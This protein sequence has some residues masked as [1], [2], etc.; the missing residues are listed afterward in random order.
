VA[1]GDEEGVLSEMLRAGMAMGYTLGGNTS[2]CQ[3]DKRYYYVE[4]EHEGRVVDAKW[5]L[6]D[7]SV[8]RLVGEVWG[9]AVQRAVAEA[10]QREMVAMALAGS[11]LGGGLF[12]GSSSE[13]VLSVT[14]PGAEAVL[15]W[16]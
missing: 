3:Y 15:W 16:R 14:A 8:Q 7:Q 10:R 2:L 11:S 13:V 9:R 12:G 5:K 6:P 1:L 4:W